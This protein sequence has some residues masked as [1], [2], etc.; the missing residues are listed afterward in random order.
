MNTLEDLKKQLMI[1]PIIEKQKQ[2]TVTLKEKVIENKEPSKNKEPIKKKIVIEEEDEP[3]GVTIINETNKGFD[4]ESLLKKIASNRLTKVTQAPIME[5][6]SENRFQ[7][8]KEKEKE[9]EK[10]KPKKVKKMEKKLLILEEEEKLDEV[11]VLEEPQVL[12]EQTPVLEEEIIIIP[13]KKERRSK[14][15][16][17]GIAVLGPESRIE[18]TENKILERIPIKQPNVNIKVSSYYMNNRE[19]FVN[20]INSMFEPY[21]K[22]IEE[23]AE[24]ITCENIGKGDGSFS[25][26][27]HQ[28]IVRDY[29]NLYTP[30]RG[31]L[32]YHSLGSGK[33]CTSIAIA[34]GMKDNKR[35]IVMTPASLR[36]N[37][38]E[39][40][41]KCGD[42]MY[43][44]NQF[45][46]WIP[47]D[48]D[49]TPIL[50][51]VLNLPIE[52]IKKNKGAWLVNIKKQS[53]YPNLSTA[54]KKS[55]D[56]QIDEMIRSKYTFINYNGLRNKRLEELT[57]GYT[58]NLFDDCVIV[59]DEA[60]NLISRI[61]N[62]IK[63]EKPIAE[64]EE[65]EK[66]HAPKFLST[67]LYEYLLSA[68]NARIVLLTGTPII[69][70]PNEFGIL[71]NILRGY[72]KTWN[73][74]LD[75]K[76]SKTTNKE[77]LQTLF[78]KE[79][80]L[81]YLDYSSSSRTLTITRNPFGFKN[82]IKETSGYRGVS[83]VKKDEEG[84]TILDTDFVSD[85]AFKKR[86]FSI[87]KSNDIDIIP[88]GIKVKNFKALPDDFDLFNGEYINSE[89]NELKNIDSLK[90]RIIGL[91]SYFR[92]AQEGLLPKFNKT[93]DDYH[94]INIPMS[95]FQFK[96]YE[97]A[98]KE[99]RK[100][101]AKSKRKTSSKPDDV[102]KEPSSTYRIFSRLFCN[103][104]MPNR[105][106]P[107]AIKRE[108]IAKGWQEPVL[109]KDGKIV[110]KEEK[111]EKEDEKQQEKAEEKQEDSS[112][113]ALLKEARN[114]E[115]GQDV[116][117]DKEGEVEG[118]EILDKIGGNE[119]KE[120]IDK[121][122]QILKE[123]SNDFL[124]PEA[125][126][127]YS[128]K[129]L[130]MLENIQDPDYVGLHL[131]YSQ[132]RTLEGIGIFSLVLNK[133]G[134]AR[135]KIKK[136]SLD[137]WEIDMK[138]EDLGKPTYAL[139]TGT[140][141][142][143]EK[144]IIRNIYNGS[145]DYIPTNIA[146]DLKKIANNNNLGEI[147]KV[148]MITS[149]G[150][151]GIN[152][153]NTRYV[154][155][156]EPYWHPVRAEQVIG[157]ARRICSHKDLPTNLQTVEVFIYLMTFSAEQLK[158]DD[159]IE[160]KQKDLSKGIPKVPV[161]SDQLLFE[162]SSIKENVSNQLTKI[163][164]ETSFDCNLY[165]HG[166]ENIVCLNF[167]D[168]TNTAFS[169]TPD[170]SKQQ[171]DI[172][173]KTNKKKIEWTG[174]SIKLY[175]IEYVYRRMSPKLLNIYDINS[176]RQALEN[177]DINPILIGTLEVNANGQQ[178]F[179]MIS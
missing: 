81:D 104:V 16:E 121:V 71:F 68:T 40:L 64:N 179:K 102:Y 12:E 126:E 140:E 49:T 82:K 55:L 20:F 100:F 141:S 151:E 30:Y 109:Y 131:V 80:V 116:N 54:E 178:V 26:L 58:K 17:K 46:E 139:Y 84:N 90:R 43:K 152:L 21:K 36:K 85:D 52:Y 110:E 132:F 125:L 101:E 56:E 37:Y 61:V 98:R 63:K 163:I 94:I 127:K 118:D 13:K 155:V 137:V 166:S 97:D 70:Y 129:F 147:I 23:N 108:K 168:P 42:P 47:A 133:N 33:S 6:L 14:K 150:S 31:V 144:E 114:I 9:K 124:T 161:T 28:K 175:G 57:N 95:N 41:K 130:A 8:E 134:F 135:F 172:T 92:S 73:I 159:S 35:I 24:K 60:H 72:I 3:E 119:Y 164:K 18:I 105:P 48:I 160:L 173:L 78:L 158:S 59:I 89:T 83:N 44:K 162:I 153:R 120:S 176:Y 27:T 11:P 51:R 138:P 69:N 50:S 65:G 1:K 34:E 10:A 157:R 111:E 115:T 87:L 53:N 149:S 113:V 174:K 7:E 93:P 77:T 177:S 32:L 5:K 145:W 117:E 96:I 123:N 146:N 169:Y 136:N 156:M 67:K 106:T 107:G 167:A 103:F 75:V 38:M 165:P 62:K 19:I 99:E 22:E 66:E 25:L 76:T 86:I 45:W 112:L 29:L 15:V 148:L 2:F 79:K 142:A 128:P 170:Y 143:E 91:T 88:Q 154:H 39:E 122:L 74:P 4:R 171:S